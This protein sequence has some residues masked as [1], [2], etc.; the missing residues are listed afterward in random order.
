VQWC[1]DHLA[2]LGATA[3]SREDYLT[4]L[5]VARGCSAVATG[6]GHA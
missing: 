2:S 1:T 5:A 4:M 6:D 3:I